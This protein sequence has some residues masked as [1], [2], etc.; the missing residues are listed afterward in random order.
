MPACI[1]GPCYQVERGVEAGAWDLAS[2]TYTYPSQESG[3][4]VDT[5][6]VTVVLSDVDD[7]AYP[8]PYS[9]ISAKTDATLGF[10]GSYWQLTFTHTSSDLDIRYGDHVVFSTPI[11]PSLVP[12]TINVSDATPTGGASPYTW[13]INSIEATADG[14][15]Y[16]DVTFDIEICPPVI[17]TASV[18]VPARAAGILPA[19]T[20]YFT[21]RAM[22]SNKNVF[23]QIESED[24]ITD[25]VGGRDILN[26]L[27][28]AVGIAYDN[29]VT[30]LYVYGVATDDATG[31]SA[32]IDELELHEVY[33]IC[34]LT[35][36]ET[37]KQ[38]YKTHVEAMSVPT[39]K[40][41]RICVI[42]SQDLDFYVDVL[43][44][45]ITSAVIS[46]VGDGTAT[47]TI[48]STDSGSVSEGDYV[49]I[50]VPTRAVG[51]YIIT[52]VATTLLTITGDFGAAVT[53]VTYMVE[54]ATT[55]VQQRDTQAAY[56]TAFGSKRVIVVFPTVL[57][58][59]TDTYSAMYGAAAIAGAISGVAPQ[60]PLSNTSIS[61]FDGR[62][63]SNDYFSELNLDYIAGGG[64]LILVQEATGAPLVIR[65]QLTTDVT[66]LNTREISRVKN[67][68]YVAKFLRSIVKPYLGKYNVTDELLG[69]LR[70]TFEG[71][72][73]YLKRSSVPKAGSVI[74]FGTLT[75]I[76]SSNDTVTAEVRV[77]IGCPFNV[78][79]INLYVS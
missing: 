36:D 37:I 74:S 41:E 19:G 6:N 3:T 64:N 22:Y 79:I 33:A 50:T 24:D 62:T 32:A 66:D 9:L 39:V 77:G 7:E 63:Y 4:T 61:G 13:T 44:A 31:H 58:D 43:D 42:G 14:N 28:Q 73:L 54:S 45:N 27:G 67:V 51:R 8:L 78:A 60:V 21:Y 17:T 57:K 72:F 20:V 26:P 56:A 40:L 49:N 23:E 2:T 55:K 16:D 34:P 47:I 71:A 76:T 48:P 11:I 30:S 53:G 29:A 10:N 12:G 1:V 35:T 38:A 59:G 75:S 65:H 69:L 46:D 18:V 5:A 15:T 68:D 52:D 70:T 25:K